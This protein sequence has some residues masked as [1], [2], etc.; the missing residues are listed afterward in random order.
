MTIVVTDHFERARE[1]IGPEAD[2]VI[3]ILKRRSSSFTA[4]CS[5]ASLPHRAPSLAR[6]HAELAQDIIAQ[7]A[8]VDSGC[9]LVSIAQPARKNVSVRRSV[10]RPCCRSVSVRKR[11]VNVFVFCRDKLAQIPRVI[12][13]S[14]FDRGLRIDGHNSL[15]HCRFPCFAAAANHKADYAEQKN[16]IDFFV[17]LTTARAPA[18]KVAAVGSRG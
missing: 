15:Q 14:T 16:W 2:A 7:R 8:C 6:H 10:G 17:P 3:A 12:L 11:V 18:S 4:F 9:A 13:N 1:N 5:A